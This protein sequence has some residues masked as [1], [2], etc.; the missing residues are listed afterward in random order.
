MSEQEYVAA[1]VVVTM[2]E[3]HPGNIDDLANRFR[4]RVNRAERAPV[5]GRPPMS[6]RRLMELVIPSTD[7]DL[8]IPAGGILVTRNNEVFDGFADPFEFQFTYSKVR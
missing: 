8:V 2:A 6:D 1:G 4:G 3:V 5:R 7:G